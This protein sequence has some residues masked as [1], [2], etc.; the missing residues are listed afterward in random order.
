MIDRSSTRRSDAGKLVSVAILTVALAAAAFAWWYQYQHGRRALE[1]WGAEGAVLIRRAPQVELWRL[2]PSPTQPTGENAAGERILGRILLD[3]RDI[4][5]ARGL[6][7]ARQALISDASY[8]WNAAPAPPEPDWDYALRFHDGSRRAT[9]VLDLDEGYARAPA[10]STPLQLG[11]TITQGLR[12]FLA[13]QFPASPDAP[14]SS[15]H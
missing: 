11:P 14:N 13:D 10:Q 12:R 15:S 7:H 6:V 9:V 4:T 3:Q 2:A 8:R 5:H 1:Y